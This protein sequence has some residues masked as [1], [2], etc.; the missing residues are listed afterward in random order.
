[1]T[2]RTA[3]TARNEAVSRAQE[4]PELT[5]ARRRLVEALLEACT[6]EGGLECPRTS[7]K[8]G[9]SFHLVSR[10]KLRRTLASRKEASR[11]GR[12]DRARI[13]PAFRDK[14][15]ER[16]RDLRVAQLNARR[17]VIRFRG[18]ERCNGII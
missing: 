13:E 5:P 14:S 10:E 4:L 12:D 18:P 8:P 15:M 9:R 6:R 3:E 16:C 11:I 2:M 17:F 7:E 1:M